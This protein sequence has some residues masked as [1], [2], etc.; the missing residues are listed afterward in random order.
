MGEANLKE[1]ST[2]NATLFIIKE[3]RVTQRLYLIC[4]YDIN[5][6]DNL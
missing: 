3:L 1:F 2:V 6:T 5:L 4:V